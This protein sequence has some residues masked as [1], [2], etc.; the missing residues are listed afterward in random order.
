M[1]PPRTTLIPTSRAISDA[2]QTLQLLLW[3][4]EQDHRARMIE[5]REYCA[6]AIKVALDAVREARDGIASY[7]PTYAGKVYA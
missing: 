4:L 7:E 6:S 1:V 2:E 5:R 3:H